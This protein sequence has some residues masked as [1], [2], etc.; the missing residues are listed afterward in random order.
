MLKKQGRSVIYGLNEHHRV[1]WN[2]PS[3]RCC[4]ALAKRRYSVKT[5]SEASQLTPNQVRYRLG[6]KKYSLNDAR[7]GLT[8][9]AQLEISRFSVS[10]KPV[11]QSQTA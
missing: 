11:K 5:I 6:L 1:S 7:N 3:N 4:M 10:R 9:S 8:P 2:D